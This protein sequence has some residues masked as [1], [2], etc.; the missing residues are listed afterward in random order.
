MK[1]AIIKEPG[2]VVLENVLDL[3]RPGEYQ[4]L[5]RNLFFASC[6]GTDLKLIHNKTPWENSYPSVL[7]HESIGEIIEVGK[8]V[9]NFAKGD[10]VLR[11]VYVYAGETL[12]GYSASF[13]GFSEQGLIIDKQAM[14]EDG[15]EGCNPYAQY[16]LTVPRAWRDQPWA[17]LFITFKETFSFLQ[18]MGSLYGKSVGVIGTGAVGL[19]FIRLARLMLAQN[20]TAINR[21]GEGFDR[22]RDFG[23]DEGV[24]VSDLASCQ[25]KFDILIDAAGVSTNLKPFTSCVKSGGTLAVYGLD[26]SFKMEIE[27]FG[28]GIIFSFHSPAEAD[29]IVHE[30]CVKL[31]EKGIIDLA[32]FHSSVM[33]F[34]RVAEGFKLLEARKE[35]KVVF[36]V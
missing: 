5:C 26:H 36:A 3:G 11:P 12:N 34:D 35:F 1:A 33:P 31:V 24:K 6:T 29:P 25:G 18:K 27:G 32:P 16:Q 30:T 10:I 9:R 17:V 4:C 2:K 7:G 13:G 21:S 22:A 8:K 20:I 28:S 15:V 23:A 14:A 19:F